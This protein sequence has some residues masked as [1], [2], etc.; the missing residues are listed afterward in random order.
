MLSSFQSARVPL[1]LLS[2]LLLCC[3]VPLCSRAQEQPVTLTF[4]AVGKD[5]HLFT[6]LRK[7]DISIMEDGVPQ[8][9]IKLEQQKD[10][11]LA[12]VFILDVSLSQETTL[13]KAKRVANAFLDSYI[14][15]GKD[16]VGVMS[17]S[18]EAILEQ[19]LTSNLNEVGKRID[20]LKAD[21]ALY[22]AL[23]GP[24]ANPKSQTIGGSAIWDAVWLASGDVLG[25]DKGDRQ[26][27]IIL[28]SDG[29]DTSSMKKMTDAVEQAIQSRV[30]IFAIGAGSDDYGVS[31]ND[32]RKI[33]E[34]TGGRAFF[35]GEKA[36]LSSV[37]AEIEQELRSRY[38]VT[39]SPARGKQSS[40]KMRK[41]KIEVVSPELRKQD[42]RLSYQQ[43]YFK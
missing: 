4:T 40:G 23:N 26:R 36:N 2:I 24:T 38:L 22:V 8:E 20:S 6:T 35:P 31:K 41:I 43:G 7:E 28:I 15:P 29:L 32:L 13:P 19:G 12:L 37:L 10:N 5:K 25:Q 30:T 34:R 9:I 11:S 3:A 39:Y 18:T 27:A 17:F 16:F 14:R 42:L 1:S 33:A 21:N